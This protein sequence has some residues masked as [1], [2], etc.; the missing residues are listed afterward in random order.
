MS[1]QINLKEIEIKLY[2]SNEVLATI[3]DNPLF[4]EFSKQVWQTK[5]LF[6][7][8]IDTENQALTAAKV[9]LR[10]RK[11]N[12]QYIQTLK[13]KGHSIGGLSERDE[14]DWIINSSQLD[15]SVLDERYWPKQLSKLDKTK[16]SAIFS[17]DFIRD[18]I[19]ID[20]PLGN[21]VAQIEVAL[22]R[23]M[24]KTAT[25]Q[26]PLNELELELREGNTDVLL[27]FAITLANKY[28]L[29]PSDTSKAERGYRLL[30]ADF[31]QF[32]LIENIDFSDEVQY[33]QHYLKSSQRL[34]ESALWRPNKQAIVNWFEQLQAMATFL[35]KTS[36]DLNDLLTPIM[37]DWQ[38]SVT[39]SIENQL[40]DK[41][42]Q[43][44]S[45][46]RW[47]VFSLSVSRWLLN[48]V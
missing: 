30:N 31:Y 25:K 22:D 5:E 40:I 19:L 11:D 7:Q 6:N 41:L 47:G 35:H 20:W 8:Y 3:K 18:Y 33:L 14:F 27:D 21:Q 32:P 42:K 26:E 38:K 13:A 37:Q 24:I 39:I 4:T 9:A 44:V 43:E 1:K 15:L 28:P 48:R 16:L 10:I 45:K 17:T 46:N 12:D 23:G 36:N 2:A 29:I 34:F